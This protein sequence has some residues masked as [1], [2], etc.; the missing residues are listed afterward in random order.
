MIPDPAECYALMS[1]YNMLANIRAHSLTVAKIAEFLGRELI[2]SGLEL[3][4]DLVVSGALLHDIGKTA[5]LHNGRDHA[6]WGAD[7][8]T[9]HGYVEIAPLVAQHVI[10]ADDLPPAPDARQIVYYA[11]KRV[12]H[13]QV[14]NLEARLAYIIERYG[15]NDSRRCAAIR[16]NFN[17]CIEIEKTIFS[18]LEYSPE[19][20]SG[21]L[22]KQSDFER[23]AA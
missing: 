20:I 7:I 4:L 8:C 2:Q 12:N 13:D 17:R 11:D 16:R 9:T 3:D 18:Y 5:C 10:L 19:D 6:L 15:L 1:Q 21:L 14:V 23:E 22:P